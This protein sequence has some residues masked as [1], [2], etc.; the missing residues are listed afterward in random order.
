MGACSSKDGVK[1]TDKKAAEPVAAA[2]DAPVAAA[3]EEAPAAEKAAEA[4]PV[5]AAAEWMIILSTIVNI[6]MKSSS[7]KLITDINMMWSQFC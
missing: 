6:F 5:A 1:D 3:G 7:I 4:E 2:A